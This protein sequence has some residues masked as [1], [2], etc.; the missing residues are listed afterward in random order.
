MI[1]ELVDVLARTPLCRDL[2]REEVVRFAEEGRVEHWPPGSLVLEEGTLGPRLIVL[3]DGRVR[4]TKHDGGGAE[5]VIAELGPGA[6]LGEISLLLQ[7]PHAATVRAITE[8]RV[9]AVER[10]TFEEMVAAGDLAALRMGF[11]LAR[12]LAGRLNAQNEKVIDLFEEIADHKKRAD[13]LRAQG[14]LQWRW[15]FR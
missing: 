15:D 7:V 6:V 2:S 9:L 11:S 8:L 13:F 12:A 5:H 10:V 14:E 4:V 1:D 3:L